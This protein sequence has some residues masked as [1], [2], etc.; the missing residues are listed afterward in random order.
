MKRVL[1]S[2]VVLCFLFSCMGKENF[3]KTHSGME[4]KLVQRDAG[5][6]PVHPGQYLKLAVVQRYGDTVLR[7]PSRTGPEYQLIDSAQMSA[8]A[9]TLFHD[10][11]IG[12]SLVF[13][14]CSDSA[15][16]NKKPAFVKKKDWLITSVKVLGIL[17]NADSVYADRER[18]R[19]K[20][21]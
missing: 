11:C 18:E 1:I 5:G 9:W 14:V 15:F 21:P 4:Y 8:E 6:V 17:E 12:D 10:A 7:E 13:R 3:T 2:V 19:E 16:K 20:Y